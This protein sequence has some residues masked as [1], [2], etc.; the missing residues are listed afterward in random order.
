ANMP[1]EAEEPER[2]GQLRDDIA[3]LAETTEALCDNVDMRQESMRRA[4]Q[5]QVALGGAVATIEALRNK[6]LRTMGDTR[7]LLQELVENVE[8]RYGALDTNQEQEIA[9]SETMDES[10][11]R[12]LSLLSGEGNFDEQ[13]NHVLDALRGGNEQNEIELF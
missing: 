9:I 6:Y 12:I 3:I 11:Q 13:F 2:A 10:V 4:E 1:G 8:R 7:L 5:L